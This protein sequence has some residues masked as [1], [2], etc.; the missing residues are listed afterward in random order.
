MRQAGTDSRNGI[1]ILPPHLRS[2]AS[3]TRSLELGISYVW[4]TST[5]VRRIIIDG[6]WIY[7]TLNLFLALQHFRKP[8]EERTLWADALCIQQTNPPEKGRQVQ[9]MGQ[10]YENSL[11]TLVWLGL[12]HDRIA[13]ETTD[14]LKETSAVARSLCEKYGGVTKIPILSHEENPVSQ[15]KRKW[16]F[17]QTFL[18]FA[19][20]SRVWVMQEVGIAPDV[21]IH[22]V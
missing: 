21:S 15:D 2:F 20:F 6:H 14:F 5:E 22:W 17:F 18:G 9:L 11:R 19:W 4:G 13:V 10:I 8:D 12:D 3:L 7:I 1:S 16:D